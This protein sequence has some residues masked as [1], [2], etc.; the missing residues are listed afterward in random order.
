MRGVWRTLDRRLL[1]DVALVC[2]AV[3][4]IGLS[5]GATAVAAGFPLWLPVVLGALVLAAGSEFL[6][7]GIIGA[8][9]SPVAAL[10][11]GLLVNA[12][13][14]PYG[15]SVPDVLG[16]GWRRVLGVHLMNDETVVMAIAQEEQERKWAAYWGCGLGILVIWPLSAAAGGLIGSVVPNTD[17]LGLDAMFPAVLLA[18]ILPA[19]RDRTTLSSAV[20]GALLALAATPFLPP[21]LPVLVALAGVLLSVPAARGAGAA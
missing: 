2:V 21:G 8:G 19:L 16:R 4:L 14:I 13:H 7:V 9:G 12:R 10:L 18:L 17:A 20:V 11:A 5:Y 6:F 15:L 3:G 1:T